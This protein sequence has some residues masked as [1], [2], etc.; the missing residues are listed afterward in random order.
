MTIP[1]ITVE[2]LAELLAAGGA[3]LFDVRQPYEFDEAH[4][5]GA[6]L[7]P[8][9]EVPD[10]VADFPSD[11]EVLVI[12]KSGGRSGQAVEFLRERGINAVNIE[13]GTMA[14]ISA[15]HPVETGGVS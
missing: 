7:I 4:V 1:E 14:W 8:L 11:R 13:G 15:G 10:R 12:C 6:T 9:G 5:P 2:R 3:A